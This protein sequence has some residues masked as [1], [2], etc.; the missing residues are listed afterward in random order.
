M[1][2]A[3]DL[4][5]AVPGLIVLMPFFAVI[6]FAIKAYDKGPVFYRQ[7]RV[8]R[9][10]KDFRIWKFR[11]MVE[12]ADRTGQLITTGGDSRITPVGEFLRKYKIDELPQLINVVCGEMSLVGPRPERA[13]FYDE[14][15][16]IVPNFR[17]RLAVL[18]E[19]TGLAQINGGYD[20]GPAEKLVWDKKYIREQS[21][22]LDIKIIFKTVL[23][24]FNHEGAR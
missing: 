9:Y 22:W 19:L 12:N 17:D 2:R 11:T 15:V 5:W 8:G 20:L 13:V 6:A 10:G 4:F 14:F 1:K 23:I 3:F 16:K 21:F 7:V 24:V 18:P